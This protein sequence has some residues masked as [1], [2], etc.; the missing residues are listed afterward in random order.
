MA[1]KDGSPAIEKRPITK[2][3]DVLGIQMLSVNRN[4]ARQ[5]PVNHDTSHTLTQIAAT[6]EI[7]V[8]WVNA[9]E[10]LAWIYSEKA[11]IVHVGDALEVWDMGAVW[12]SSQEAMSLN[13][14]QILISG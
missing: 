14:P 12:F 9:R 6:P 5:L 3:F 13:I 8:G 11:L 10:G 4:I 1:K 7:I 2:K